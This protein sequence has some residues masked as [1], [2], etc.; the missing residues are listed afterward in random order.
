MFERI[1]DKKTSVA[2]GSFD[3]LH[4]GHR[5]VVM[6]AAEESNRGLVPVVLLFD[7][8]PLSAIKNAPPEAITTREELENEIKTLNAVPVTVSFKKIM[9]M[10]P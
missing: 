2:L 10:T 3:G 9:N 8:H 1:F 4:I 6:N 7:E 5:A